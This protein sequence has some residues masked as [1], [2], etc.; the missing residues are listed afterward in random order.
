MRSSVAEEDDA[1]AAQFG[2]ELQRLRE[3]AGLSQRA[4]GRAIGTSGQQVG[5]VE[6]AKRS[7]SKALAEAADR[8]LEANGGLLA[9]WPKARRTTHRWLEDYVELEGKAQALLIFQNQI[10]P[11]LFQTA[12]YARS[13]LGAAWPPHSPDRVEVLLEGRLKRQELL[14]RKPEPVISVVLD[15]AALRRGPM[16][17]D[18]MREQLKHLVELAGRPNI[19][20]NLLPFTAG[21]HPGTEGSYIV[22]EMSQT[23]SV[24]YM[25]QPARGQVITELEVVASCIRRFGSLRARS[26][27]L[28]ESTA[29]VEA[30]I[31]GENDG[32]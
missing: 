17:R 21:F 26:L 4:L 3:L 25:E 20:L 11:G 10:V 22:L 18:I 2:A 31:E 29:F 15:E 7:P 5:A 30:L 14:S 27:S 12:D 23:E 13:L 16:Q 24:V 28:G 32:S 19:E 8:V 9:L 1:A 6:R